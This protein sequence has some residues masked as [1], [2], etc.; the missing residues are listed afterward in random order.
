M[1]TQLV[2]INTEYEQFLDKAKTLNVASK[3]MALT[4]ARSILSAE[5]SR[6]L[7]PIVYGSNMSPMQ[8]SSNILNNIN[9][10]LFSNGN[11]INILEA[12]LY[13][14]FYKILTELNNSNGVVFNFE[15]KLN[16]LCSD[17]QRTVYY[18]ISILS[19]SKS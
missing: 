14:E 13:N 19:N 2:K 4:V 15:N 17:V 5:L 10:E 18:V 3:D 12:L 6:V 8:L 11:N 1:K 9:L 16:Q 7:A